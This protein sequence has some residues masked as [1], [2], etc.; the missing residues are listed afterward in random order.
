[1]APD[2]TSPNAQSIEGAVEIPYDIPALRAAHAAVDLPAQWGFWR[3]VGH[4][5]TAFFVESFVDEL[6]HAAGVDPLSFRL[7]MLGNH[8]RHA[9]VLK[10][11][12]SQA[13]F[14]GGEDGTARGIALHE[15]FGSIVAMVAEV[16]V[17]PDAGLAVRRITAA[18]DC[19]L[20][21]NP[22]IVRA[23]LEGGILYGLSA[24]LN[25]AVTFANGFPE[26]ANFD[27]YPL[28]GMA[29]SPDIELVLFESA[30]RPGGVGEIAVPPVAPAVANAVFA[31]T[32]VRVRDLPLAGKKLA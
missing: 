27:S 15:S 24:A 29:E 4:S 8:P 30:E 28:L 20:I 14:M 3:S 17:D 19:G 25:G 10:L 9:E 16:E 1:M 32:G 31:A 2:P 22:D 11:A 13:G 23:Q 7:R 6:A 12:A 5:F 26:Q 18:A 21:V